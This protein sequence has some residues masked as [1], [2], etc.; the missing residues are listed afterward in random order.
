VGHGPVAD[1]R[2]VP[3]PPTAADPDGP[4]RVVLVAGDEVSAFDY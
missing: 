2:L 1:V 3:L 4:T